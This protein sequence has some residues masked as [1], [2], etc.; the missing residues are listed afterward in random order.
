MLKA[1]V[2]AVALWST[3]CRHSSPKESL[4]V[5]SWHY[6]GL[7]DASYVITFDPDHT[8][9]VWREVL[10][11]SFIDCHGSWRV[12]GDTIVRDITYPRPDLHQSDPA[13]VR[14]PI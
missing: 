7:M 14:E 5:G 1:L 10:G 4:L 6:K 8:F 11:H 12:E 13:H 3:G 2:I 9:S